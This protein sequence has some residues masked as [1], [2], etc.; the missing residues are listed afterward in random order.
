MHLQI[1]WHLLDL[2]II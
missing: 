2:D 1:S